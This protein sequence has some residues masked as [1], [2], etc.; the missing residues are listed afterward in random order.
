MDNMSTYI[1]QALVL[2][3]IGVI[4]KFLVPYVKSQITTQKLSFVKTWVD[5]LVNAAEQKIQGSKMG[6]EKK[7]WVVDM[8]KKLGIVVDDSVDA[9][10]ESAVLVLNNAIDSASK[11]I[12]DGLKT[13]P[14][15]NASNVLAD[16]ITDATSVTTN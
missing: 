14:I 13:V 2:I 9:L 1:T 4:T 5:S 10:I 3:L 16:A 11:T 15:N 12:T 6:A 8:L 7:K